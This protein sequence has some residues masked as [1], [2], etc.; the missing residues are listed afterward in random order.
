MFQ[1][2][3]YTKH[4]ISRPPRIKLHLFY[5]VPT[6]RHHGVNLLKQEYSDKKTIL[7]FNRLAF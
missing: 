3:N 6:N 4:F 7:V 2:R 1:R 5:N